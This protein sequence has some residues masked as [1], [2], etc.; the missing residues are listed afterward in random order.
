MDMIQD[1]AE[2][3]MANLKLSYREY[4]HVFDENDDAYL[5]TKFDDTDEYFYDA[6]NKV[7]VTQ[8]EIERLVNLCIRA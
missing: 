3:A 8:G 2:G 1:A 5:M 7:N 4:N 6:I